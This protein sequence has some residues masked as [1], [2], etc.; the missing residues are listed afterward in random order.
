M[1][2]IDPDEDKLSSNT[3]VLKESSISDLMSKEAKER[4]VVLGSVNG[5]VKGRDT[6]ID[7]TATLHVNG[8]KRTIDFMLG[9]A[10]STY[11]ILLPNND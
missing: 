7:L 1:N 8:D 3:D 6:S 2:W 11:D 10:E 5:S 9:G 4:T